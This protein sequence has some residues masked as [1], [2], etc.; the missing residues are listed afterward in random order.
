[1]IN[2]EASYNFILNKLIEI[3]GTEN[4]YFK[5]VKPKLSDIELISL[6]ILAE[7]KSIDSEYQLFREIKG[8]AIE[9]K[10]ERS[11]YNRRKRKLFPFLE[12]IRCKMVKKFNDFENYFL[13]DSMPLEVCK[14]S[15]SSRS[16]ICKENSLKVFVL[17]KIY[18]FMVTS[19]M[20]SV[21][22]LVCS[23]VLTYLPPLFTT[24]II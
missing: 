4:F 3:S 2:L 18:T 14:L 12:E 1:M 15:R 9:S 17:L 21:L 20:R 13:V 8:W 22:L 16:K 7:F 6:I 19:Y 23:K 24:F 10:I 5:P 11:V